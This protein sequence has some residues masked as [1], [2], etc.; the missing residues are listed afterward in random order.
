MTLITCPKNSNS[1]AHLHNCARQ[2]LVVEFAK[3]SEVKNQSCERQR[4]IQLEENACI[5]IAFMAHLMHT[6]EYENAAGTGQKQSHNNE[7]EII[8]V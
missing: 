2:K 7:N 1:Y 5:H 6:T 3:F 8:K 4:R